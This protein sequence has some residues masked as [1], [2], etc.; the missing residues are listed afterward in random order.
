VNAENE[1]E[2]GEG[3][4]AGEA[5]VVTETLSVEV[6]VEEDL[7]GVDLGFLDHLHVGGIRIAVLAE[8]HLRR[9]GLIRMYQDEAG[10]GEK[11]EE[12]HQSLDPPPPYL[13]GRLLR[14][15]HLLDVETAPHLDLAPLLPADADPD[16]QIDE[17]LGAEEAE[18]EDEAQIVEHVEDLQ[19]LL[20]FLDLHPRENEEDFP[21]SLS[22]LLPRHVPVVATLSLDPDPDLFLLL[23]LSAVLHQDELP[24]KEELKYREVLKEV[25]MMIHVAPVRVVIVMNFG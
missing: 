19:H 12:D 5:D 4:T 23:D 16:H 14:A 10:A 7:I 15:P 8:V 18:G 11:S 9:E 6:E 21:P 13:P 22:V 20:I 25:Q 3:E 17:T 24:G 2:V 1:V